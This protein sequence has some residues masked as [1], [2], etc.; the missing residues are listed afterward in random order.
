MLTQMRYSLSPVTFSREAL[1]VDPDPWQAEVMMSPAKRILLNCS[2]QSGKSTTSSII[3]LHRALYYP[4]SLI[5]LISPSLRQSSELFK[6]VQQFYKLLP[7]REKLPEDNRLSMTLDNGSRIVSLPSSE[8]NIRGFSAVSLVIEDEASRVDDDLYRAIRPM[9]AVSEGRIM[10][11][12]TPWGK[13]GH[14]FEEWSGSNEWQRIE[15]PAIKCS[16]ISP[17]FLQ[18]E[19]NALGNWWYQQEYE[20][21]FSATTDSLF[22]YDT[23]INAISDDVKPLFMEMV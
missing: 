23:V 8:S 11:M 5:L 2:R 14:F 9:L 19:K 1:S 10:L 12:S 16:R 17:E 6:K 20:C 22:S 15:I 4:G 18:E 13:R 21:Q 3:A 7:D